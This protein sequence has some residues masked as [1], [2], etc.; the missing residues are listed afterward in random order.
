[1]DKIKDISELP[2]K[3]ILIAYLKEAMEL[4]AS[5]TAKPK[6]IKEKPTVAVE[7]PEAFLEALQKD[8]KANAF[9]ESKSPSF[10]KNYIVWVADAKTEETRQKKD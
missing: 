7:P 6:P 4:N 10:R 8:P 2:D 1:M 3:K 5:G 9:F